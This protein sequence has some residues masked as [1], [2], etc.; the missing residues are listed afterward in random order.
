MLPAPW[1]R[2][3]RPRAATAAPPGLSRARARRTADAG[4]L[5][6]VQAIVRQLTRADVLP[7]LGFGP[8]EQR[9]DLVQTMLHV[10]LHGLAVSAARRLFAAQAGDPAGITGDC[11][12]EGLH[13]TDAAALE[14]RLEA[15]IEAV[16]TLARH[17]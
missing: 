15:L 3:A 9:T 4:K 8:I 11:A 13:F 10:P 5:A 6:I 1:L 12:S 7:D 2:P 17:Q 14:A 16:H